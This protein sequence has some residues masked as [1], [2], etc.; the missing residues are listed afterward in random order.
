MLIYFPMLIYFLTLTVTATKVL[1]VNLVVLS[2]QL[3]S[4]DPKGFFQTKWS[5][6]FSFKTYCKSFQYKRFRG[7]FIVS[8]TMPADTVVHNHSHLQCFHVPVIE[9]Q[10]FLF[11]NSY[12]QQKSLGRKKQQ[13]KNSLIL[14]WVPEFHNP[15][16][17][18]PKFDKKRYPKKC[19]GRRDSTRAEGGKIWTKC[20]HVVSGEAGMS[21][22]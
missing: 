6:D 7:L 21:H 12:L 4:N 11:I 3:D 9:E 15:S 1:G 18:I 20:H 16:C 2:L 19:H 13:I 5:C 22:G 10:T 8:P 14:V 17:T